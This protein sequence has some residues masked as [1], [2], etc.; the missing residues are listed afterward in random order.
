MSFDYNALFLD[1]LETISMCFIDKDFSAWEGRIIYPLSL[2]TAQG[3]IVLHSKEDAQENFD[4]YLQACEVMRLDH[5]YRRPISLE[6]CRDGQFIGTY[7]TNLLSH[8]VRATPPYTSS[9][10]LQLRDG[11]FC[12]QS[13]LNAR[14][15]HDWT[16]KQPDGTVAEN[17]FTKR[18]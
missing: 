9:A 15:H 1:F 18:D 2:I 10:M 4:L 8:G 3:P 13:I 16:G 17:P 11:Q 6:D 7:E 5:I 14:G 12:M